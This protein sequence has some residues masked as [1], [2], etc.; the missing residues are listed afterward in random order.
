MTKSEIPVMPQFF[1]RYINQVDN[2]FLMDALL[3]TPS[4]DTYFPAQT[5]EAIGDLRYA[6]GKWMVKDILQHVIDTERIMA[7]RA[8]RFARNDKTAL[9][10]YD[11]NLF[12]ETA[13]A[14]RRTIPD[15]Y[16]EFA[17]VRQSSI[18][19]FGSFDNEML[20]RT[21][22]CYHQNI[23]VLALGFVVVGHAR[24]HATIIKERYLP[25]LL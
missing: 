21:G 11:E 24:H 5:L 19:L 13:H 4:F 17:A 25:L 7:Y 10:G 6:P 8:L 18:L 12:A 23:S 20:L 14:T 16:A 9:P 1:D 22:V 15:L 2:V 3:Q